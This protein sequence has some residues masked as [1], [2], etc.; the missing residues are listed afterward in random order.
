MGRTSSYTVVCNVDVPQH[1]RGEWTVFFFPVSID[2]TIFFLNII[3][4]NAWNR[5]PDA[6]FNAKSVCT[7]C[8]A[9]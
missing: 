5:V 1:R 2:V 7:T 3:Q 9:T 6:S 4:L 8:L